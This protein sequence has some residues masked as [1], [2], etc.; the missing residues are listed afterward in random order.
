VGDD[1]A[2]VADVFVTD[3]HANVEE[4]VLAVQVCQ[5]AHEHFPGVEIGIA[6][7]KVVETAITAKEG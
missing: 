6:F 7:E 4:D 5:D 2:I 3:G 1:A